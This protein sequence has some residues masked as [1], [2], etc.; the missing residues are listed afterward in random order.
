MESWYDGNIFCDIQIKILVVQQVMYCAAVAMVLRGLAQVMNTN[1]SSWSITGAKKRRNIIIDLVCCVGLPMLQMLAQWFTQPFRYYILG[2]AGCVPPT[3]GSWLY[4]LLTLAPSVAWA[5]VDVYYSGMSIPISESRPHLADTDVLVQSCYS[6]AWSAIAALSTRL[7]LPII[8]PN[9]GFYAFIFFP[10]SA[11]SASSPLRST[12]SGSPC[13]QESRA[14]PGMPS[15]TPLN[16]LGTPSSW[17][18]LKAGHTPTVGSG[19][20]VVS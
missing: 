7:W 18:H 4:I 19:S 13:V 10:R 14:S 5:V 9:L 17:F 6:P 16:T 2:I 11:F 1:S 15:I 20:R 8:S 3:D 12:F